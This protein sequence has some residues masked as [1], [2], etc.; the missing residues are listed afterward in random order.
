MP[1][2]RDLAFNGDKF[3]EPDQKVKK[4]IENWLLCTHVAKKLGDFSFRKKQGLCKIVFY[5]Q[6]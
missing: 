4:L 5:S 6:F 1:T 2:K 3:L